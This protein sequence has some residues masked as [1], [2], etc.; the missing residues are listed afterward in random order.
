MRKVPM[1]NPTVDAMKTPQLNY[2]NT[3]S[4]KQDGPIYFIYITH[5]LQ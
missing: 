3:L 4:F 5:Y 1:Y 2:S